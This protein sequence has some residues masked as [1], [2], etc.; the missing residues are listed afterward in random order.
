MKKVSILLVCF[1]VNLVFAIPKCFAWWSLGSIES[2]HYI[3]GDEAFQLISPAD[4][5]D[6]WQTDEEYFGIR[7]WI[8]GGT[9]D[10]NAHGRKYQGDAEDFNGGPID[11]WWSVK[12]YPNDGVLV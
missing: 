11:R 6:L 7:D 5:P 2:T 3:L 1:L 8:T 12:T 10:V 4:Y 9:N